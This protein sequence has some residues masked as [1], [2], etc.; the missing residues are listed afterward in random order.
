[1]LLLLYFRRK[2]GDVNGDV[3]FSG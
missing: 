1:L 3:A 2:L